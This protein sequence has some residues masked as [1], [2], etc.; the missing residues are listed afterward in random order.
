ME[1]QGELLPHPVPAKKEKLIHWQ[2]PRKLVP[3][4][5]G[6][7]YISINNF[8]FGGGNTHVVLERMPVLHDGGAAEEPS[9]LAHK[10]VTLSGHDE[11]AVKEQGKALGFYLEQHPAVF[12]ASLLNNLA[13]TLCQRR[14]VFP[15]R[16]VLS[17]SATGDLIRQLS[18]DLKP[19]RAPASPVV[20]FVFT[21]QGA[22]WPAMGRELLPTYPVFRET[23]EAVD[24]CL[25]SLGATFSIIGRCNRVLPLHA[26]ANNDLQM[27]SSSVM[28]RQVPS[29]ELT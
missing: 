16:V 4:P 17:G 15:W 29:P 13:Y 10:V 20:G 26:F 25:A 12:D 23:M 1:S 27:R 19:S 6:K 11:R 9:P 21:G 8:G 7:R 24:D 5:R 22:Q 18:S 14:T 3:W 2:V 28:L